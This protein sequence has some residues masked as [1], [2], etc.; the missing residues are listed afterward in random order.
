VIR[1]V[2]A[3]QKGGVG[4]TTA[5]VNFSWYLS[6]RGYR[7]LLIDTD[8][9]GSAACI[10]N[11]KPKN[12][13][14]HF[15]LAKYP[16][17]ECTINLKE[18]L[19][20]LCGN[21]QTLEAESAL[22][23]VT[24]R[25]LSLK[26]VLE[27]YESQYGAV[28]LDASP[29]LGLVQTCALVYARNVVIPVNMDLLSLNGANAA[30]ETVRVLNDLLDAHIRAVGFMP[31]QV[32]R[33]LSITSWVEQG[34]QGMSDMLGVPILPAIRTDQTVN[35]AYRARKPLLQ[36]DPGARAAQDYRATFEKIIAVIEEQG[37]GKQ[38]AFA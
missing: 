15:L 29:S 23:H 18:R 6:E 25:E 4:K 5:A 3:N 19:D 33:Q 30:Y 21:K 10:L 27:P 14:S 16:L 24:A 38:E 1:V 9:Q 28:I 12:Y 32:N 36:Y 22:A 26:A 2:F 31:C 37:C 20:V 35:R 8:S 34:L 7:T 11:L 13:F 17:G